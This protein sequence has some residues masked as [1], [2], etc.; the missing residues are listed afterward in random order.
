MKVILDTSLL[1]TAI[2]YKIDIFRELRGNDIFVLNEIVNELERLKKGRSKT[3]SHA[4][5][6]L[7]LIKRKD[8]SSLPSEMTADEELLE[9]SKKGFAIATQDFALKDRIKNSGGKAFIIRKKKLI[10]PD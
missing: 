6:A 9:Y 4:K 3:A 7:E 2:K 5:L 1:I 8:I 10:V